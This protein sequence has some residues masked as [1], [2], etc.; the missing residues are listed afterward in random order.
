MQ[1]V[2]HRAALGAKFHRIDWSSLPDLPGPPGPC[3]KRMASL[4]TNI[5]FR[6]AVMR[7]CNMLS[8]RYANHLEKTPN[9]LLNLD[10]CRQVRG[11]LAGLNKNLSVGV[12]H[13]E[14]SNSEGERW[15]DFEDKNIKIALDEVIQCKW[16]S[17]VESL[18]QVRTLSEEWSNLNMD[19][20]GNV[21]SHFALAVKIFIL[22]IDLSQVL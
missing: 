3:G 8:Q 15:D 9:K 10:D 19:A 17:K 21:S 5:K 7:L 4:N 14:A 12:E 18:K 16:M 6:K 11:S 2:R 20:E 1:Y 13:A 22:K